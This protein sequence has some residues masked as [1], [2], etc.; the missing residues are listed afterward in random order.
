M[1]LQVILHSLTA[2]SV[3]DKSINTACLLSSSWQHYL[4][5]RMVHQKPDCEVMQCIQ[6]YA[7]YRGRLEA[8][9]D[10]WGVHSVA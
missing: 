8:L 2:L 5:G 6:G 7:C 10:S 9:K 4:D 3:F 1:P